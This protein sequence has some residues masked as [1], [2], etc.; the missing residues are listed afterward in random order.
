[1]VL[2][3]KNLQHI[4]I[5]KWFDTDWSS[6]S[7]SPSN[8]SPNAGGDWVS[9]IFHESL[10]SNLSLDDLITGESFNYKWL[11]SQWYFQGSTMFSSYIR[12]MWWKLWTYRKL[13]YLKPIKFD[14]Q[15]PAHGNFFYY[16]ISRMFHRTI[17]RDKYHI[18]SLFQ[19][20]SG[21]PFQE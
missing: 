15:W 3:N 8:G 6:V 21:F 18:C 9:R 14:S 1:M 16:I 5:S 20:I 10:G 7:N 11:K 19:T 4:Y 13:N 2:G 12:N 17:K